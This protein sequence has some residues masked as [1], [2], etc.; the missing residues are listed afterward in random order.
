MI[1]TADA[2]P[3][4]FLGKINQ[5]SLI[6]ELFNAEI[7][8]PSV[9]KN[10]IFGPNVPPDEERLLTPFLSKCKVVDIRNPVVFA[11]AMSF[12]D[13]CVL[14]LACREHADIILSD[15]R[16]VRRVAVIEGVRVVGTLG[17]LI[18]AKKKSL[19]S[20]SNT[21]DL[22]D[23]LVEEHNFR[24]STRVYEAARKAILTVQGSS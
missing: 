2:A 17:V 3:V 14:T 13:N 4:I 6:H 15:D 11:K 1:L 19:L 23:Q 24:I 16:L 8:I 5:L 7:L 21:E 9:V 10:E 22:L 18:R 12:A 20:T